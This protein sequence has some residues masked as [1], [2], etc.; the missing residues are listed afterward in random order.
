MSAHA[1]AEPAPQSAPIRIGLA[2][3]GGGFRATLYHLG[4][5]RFLY[6]AGLLPS[7]TQICCVSGGSIFGAHLVQNWDRYTGSPEQFQ[8][9]ADEI[10]AF[11]RADL[12]G[13]VIRSW[14]FS[15]AAL[16][17]PRLFSPSGWTR[18]GV[19]R[20]HY[21]RLY[22]RATLQDLMADL[23]G[24]KPRPHLH[25]LATSMTTGHMVSFGDG[26]MKI[27]DG[28]ENDGRPA[29]G[30]GGRPSKAYPAGSLPVSVAVAASSAFPPLFPP[31]QVNDALFGAPE[32]FLENEHYLADGGV[33]DNLGIRKLLWLNREPGQGFELV[34]VSDAQREN[35]KTFAKPYSF[36]V[37]RATRSSDLMMMRVSALENDAILGLT[38]EAKSELLMCR[39]SSHVP[40]NR[41]DALTDKEQ[42]GAQQ[43]RTDLDSFSADEVNAL[44]HHG[45]TA[46]RYAWTEGRT[47]GRL[48]RLGARPEADAVPARAACWTPI[49]PTPATF[50]LSNSPAM[51][52]GLF[53]PSDWAW[54]SL[55]SLVLLYAGLIVGL[56]VWLWLESVAAKRR[57][58]IANVRAAQ[59]I[60]TAEQEKAHVEKKYRLVRLLADAVLASNQSE[61]DEAKRQWDDYTT[62]LF[63][64][65]TFKNFLKADV[66][67]IN[68][69]LS[70]K[71]NEALR[72]Q[73]LELARKVGRWA[74]G[75]ENEGYLVTLRQMR[76]DAYDDVT[77]AA[78]TIAKYP[79][80]EATPQSQYRFWK[81]YWGQ[82]GLFE[83]SEVESAMWAYGSLLPQPPNKMEGKIDAELKENLR[84]R[85]KALKKACEAEIKAGRFR[86]QP[87]D[88][89]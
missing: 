12:R 26:Q 75:A 40:I 71:P 33:F 35:S 66:D 38:H 85:A 23:P 56:F 81:L 10:V 51:K 6:E 24:G 84:E 1:Q 53:R 17:L 32:G 72:G 14:A 9:A 29:V 42:L 44:V 48:A 49:R 74:Q 5:I 2:L 60:Q 34:V 79:N 47:V 41:A 69:N 63:E 82:M 11:T 16:G 59:A 55:W 89:K 61:F 21:D 15:F 18:T 65:A 64:E 31:V 83:G 8:E 87:E 58:E 43:V 68:E 50:D 13:K 62:K 80:F 25:V 22:N 52:W 88:G 45:A 19:L 37:S 54:W 7:V 57:E 4:V 20:A 46:A 77:H 67:K 30:G 3:S 39:L 86:Y 36:L 27:H 76:K 73:T 28:D 78:K 70:W